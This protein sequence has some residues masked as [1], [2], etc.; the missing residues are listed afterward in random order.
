MPCLPRG[1]ALSL[2]LV[3]IA[4]AF[5]LQAAASC[6]TGSALSHEDIRHVA[7]G[8]FSLTGQLHPSFSYQGHLRW[9]R[10]SL[11]ANVSLDA[12]RAVKFKGSFVAV[13]QMNTF[14][15]IV[16][17]LQKH[18]FFNMRLNPTTHR[19]IDGPEDGRS[20]QRDIFRTV[21]EPNSNTFPLK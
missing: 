1:R 18:A 10:G 9:V 5:P 8:Q 11:R 17:V 15:D 7:V 20:A 6:V 19:Y 14:R 2:L 13:D 4:F 12:K 21:D 3:S 16:T